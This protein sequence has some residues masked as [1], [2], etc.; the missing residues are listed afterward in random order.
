MVIVSI[1]RKTPSIFPKTTEDV[2]KT[3]FA[4]TA[5]QNAEFGSSFFQDA[6]DFYLALT[7]RQQL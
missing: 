6:W 2:C 1:T 4:N 7:F 3:L 5:K